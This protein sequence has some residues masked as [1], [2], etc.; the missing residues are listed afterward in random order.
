MDVDV[1]I[2]RFDDDDVILPQA[3]PFPEMVRPEA[4]LSGPLPKVPEESES[5]ES[6]EAPQRK[7]RAP[8]ELPIDERQELHNADLAQ[9]KN[10]YLAN[11]AEATEAKNAH[12]AVTLAKKNAAYW[13]VGAGIGGVGAGLGVSKMKSPLDMFAGDAMMEALTGIKTSTAGQKRGRDDDED[14][15]SDSE[16]RRT[17]IRDDEEQIGRG[18]RMI[19]DDDGAV[20]QDISD[21]RLLHIAIYCFH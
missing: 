3:E 16:A 2:P 1:D 8:K 18:E 12:K 4:D 20:I 19:L 5:S 6:V 17:R 10:E 7:R 9:W 21:V 13:V 11:M 14:H 15:E